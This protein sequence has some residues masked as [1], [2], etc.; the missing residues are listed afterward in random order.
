MRRKVCHCFENY[1]PDCNHD[2]ILA[3]YELNS[4]SYASIFVLLYF[5]GFH[6]DLK[7]SVLDSSLKA[8]KEKSKNVVQR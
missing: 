6:G 2:C 3:Y 8:R 7:E 4:Q 1:H 5:T